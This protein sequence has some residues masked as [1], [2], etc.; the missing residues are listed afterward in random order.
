MRAEARRELRA[1]SSTS[2]CPFSSFTGSANTLRV[3]RTH[4][5][6]SG[7]R[8]RPMK[9]YDAVL[10]K[11]LVWWAAI[12]ASDD[13]MCDDCLQ[14]NSQERTDGVESARSSLSAR[15][16]GV[17]QGLP[18]PRLP[19]EVV[20]WHPLTRRGQGEDTPLWR[21]GWGLASGSQ[22]LLR[23]SSPRP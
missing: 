17:S 1:R 2:S 8:E 4:Q 5:I 15:W 13:N 22:G 18:G 11:P 3:T 10:L 9:P 7:T 16:L 19:S 12:R 6:V 23:A 14:A 20:S 21:G